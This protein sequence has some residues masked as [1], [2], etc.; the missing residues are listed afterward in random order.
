MSNATN[1]NTINEK[2]GENIRSIRKSLNLTQEQ[3]AEKL[4]INCQFLSQA[5]N[6]K[7]GISIDTAINLC[8]IAHC[9]STHLF[10]DIIKS[11]NII[12]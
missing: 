11:S 6:G 4:N 1:K 8:N 5:E 3:L 9:S 10:K 7:S 2:L 12:D